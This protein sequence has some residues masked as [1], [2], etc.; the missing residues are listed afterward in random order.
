M[1]THALMFHQFHDDEKHIKEQGSI[2][3][4][5]F[6]DMIIH[7]RKKFN[8]LSAR[9][10]YELA[11][12]DKLSEKD[13]CITFDDALR[14]QYDIAFP[15]LEEFNIKAFWFIYS[16][17][18]NNVIEK[19]ELYRYF[20]FKEFNDINDFYDS[21]N[22][23]ID[24]SEYRSEVEVALRGFD[25]EHHLK[26]YPFYTKED[27]VFRFLR[28]DVLGAKKYHH[29]MDDMISKSGIRK[30]G[31]LD[32]LWMDKNGVKE[33]KE[34]GH[35]IGLHSHTH[36]TKLELLDKNEQEKEYIQ[37]HSVLSEIVGNEIF[38]MSHPNGSYN[39]DTL[40]ILKKLKV[41]IG[42]RANMNVGGGSKLEIPRLDHT[43]LIKEVRK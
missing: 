6:A 21:F 31:L 25:H 11:I 23:E 35:I 33:L 15:V 39:K 13:V 4:K 10:W 1:K 5:E 30:D 38:S 32:L 22:K 12:A 42:F 19:L 16:S 43:Y 26:E 17:P 34:K 2:T 20:R 14:S 8:I 18:L 40:D 41:Q 36:P 24:N 3:G 27:K 7:Y 29:L 37:N 9:E 28:D